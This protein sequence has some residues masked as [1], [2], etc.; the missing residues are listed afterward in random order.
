M[1]DHASFSVKDYQAGIA[2]Y[3][4]PLPFL[5][6]TRFAIFPDAVRYGKD[7]KRSLW[8]AQSRKESGQIGKI[9]EFH[10]VFAAPSCAAIQAW[11]EAC[12]KLGAHDN[13]APDPCPEYH[14]GYHEVFMIE[15]KA[16]RLEV[17]LHTYVAN[18][19]ERK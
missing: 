3:D 2:F 9:Q 12:V 17:G 16:W 19:A 11:Y 14:P 7:S 18:E 10:S 4:Q 5:G 1:L 13:G 8:G 6:Y 15:P